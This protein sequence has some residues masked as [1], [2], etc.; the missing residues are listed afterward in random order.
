MSIDQVCN[1]NKF[2]FCKHEIV[3][4][5]STSGKFVK[6]KGVVEEMNVTRDIL[7]NVDSFVTTKGVSLVNTVPL[8]TLSPLMLLKKN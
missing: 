7:G 8:I 4:G 3:V 1:H 6:I 2:G 5:K